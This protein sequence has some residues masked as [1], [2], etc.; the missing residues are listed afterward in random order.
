MSLSAVA[1]DPPRG[2][3]G[4]VPPA[5]IR[6]A[7]RGDQQAFAAIVRHYDPG[8]RALAYRMLGDRDRM[9]DVLQDAYLRAYR[10]LPRF[11]GRSNLGTWLYRIVYNAS[12]DELRRA[13]AAPVSPFEDLDRRPER[14]PGVPET[15]EARGDLAAA[16]SE[17]DPRDRATVLLVDAFGFDYGDAA[18]VLDIPEGTVASRLNRA[19]S[20]LRR[21]L[22][23]RPEGVAHNA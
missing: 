8:L 23:A 2:G 15:V 7:R 1:Q 9:D 21:A 17:L 6:R 18:R 16:L 11:R 13:R 3:R 19:R 10:S 12:L 4:E 20:V 22:R 14:R 5:V